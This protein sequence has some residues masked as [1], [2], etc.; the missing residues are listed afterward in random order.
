ML[1]RPGPTFRHKAYEAY[2]ATRKEID[3]DLLV[4][5][6]L[7]REMTE[8]MGFKT[9]EKPGFEADDLMATLAV[10]AQAAGMEAV[11]SPGTRTCS[12]WSGP[13]SRVHNAAKKV[14]LDAAQVREKLGVEPEAVVAFLAL[15][16]DSSDNVPGVK[17]VGPVGAAKL[18]KSF[19]SLDALLKA[20]KRADPAI[21][22]KPRK[23][24]WTGRRRSK[25]RKS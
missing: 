24:F 23:L 8:V 14:W 13:E 10:R 15:T 19:G 9:V 1:R 25:R 5:L 22:E 21:P 17:G 16:G 11:W 7:A 3:A 20:A 18:L 6:K 4:Q 12:S 2:K